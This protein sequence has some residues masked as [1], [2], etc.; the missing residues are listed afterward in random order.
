MA[1][2][3]PAGL[4]IGSSPL[5]PAMALHRLHVEGIAAVGHEPIDDG[6][7]VP[8]ERVPSDMRAA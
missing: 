2:L 4:L 6:L 7:L 1:V 8:P 5:P 3:L